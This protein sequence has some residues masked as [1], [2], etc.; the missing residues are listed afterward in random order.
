[1]NDGGADHSNA[2]CKILQ[3]T[4]MYIYSRFQSIVMKED[5]GA[6]CNQM[7]PCPKIFEYIGLALCTGSSLEMQPCPKI[8]ESIRLAIYTGSSLDLGISPTTILSVTLFHPFSNFSNSWN[9][10]FSGLLNVADGSHDL[11]LCHA[12]I[13]L[14]R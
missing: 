14:G 4:N 13:A 7:Q 3:G 9:L 2:H 8:S 10:V 1:M 12:M 6:A 5:K 11:P